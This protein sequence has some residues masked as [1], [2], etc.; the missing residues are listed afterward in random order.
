MQSN[1]T[2]STRQ[3]LDDM[4]TLIEELNKKEKVVVGASMRCSIL[5]D[6]IPLVDSV[7]FNKAKG[8][9]IMVYLQGLRTTD[10]NDPVTDVTS[11]LASADA[12]L[13]FPSGLENYGVTAFGYKTSARWS[14]QTVTIDKQGYDLY[15]NKV[16]VGKTKAQVVLSFIVKNRTSDSE[17]FFEDLVGK[18]LTG[19]D[20]K[21]FAWLLAVGNTITGRRLTSVKVNTKYEQI[22]ELS[23]FNP[24][25]QIATT[26]SSNPRN[27]YLLANDATG[28]LDL[29]TVETLTIRKDKEGIVF[30]VF[31]TKNKMTWTLQLI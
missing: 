20:I 27:M 3:T 11:I 30:L 15:Q 25:L 18:V 17:T 29:S 24:L 14:K 9:P 7:T 13:T 4:D 21:A 12:G 10:T 5:K 22:N 28:T 19:N 31:T 26:K 6:A 23:V 1:L 16:V 8:E 2:K